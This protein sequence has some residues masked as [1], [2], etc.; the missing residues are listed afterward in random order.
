MFDGPNAVYALFSTLS[1]MLE[2][3][4]GAVLLIDALDECESGPE[5]DQLLQL[6]TKH[7]KSPTKAKWLLASRNYSSIKQLLEE[8]SETLSLE[9]NEQHISRAVH[10]FI[11][12]KTNELVMK[13]KYDPD[14]AEKVKKGLT[15]KANSTF[16]WVSLACKSLAKASRWKTLSTLENLPSG[17]G[18][19]YARMMD[20]VLQ[21]EDEED[22]AFCM[23]ILRSVSLSFRPLLM[24][25]LIIA[26]ELPKEFLDD[27]SISNSISDLIELCGSFIIVR[28]RVPYFVHQSAKDYLV[29]DGSQRLF[30]PG[31]RL[32]HGLIVGRSLIAMSNK[33]KRNMGNLRYSGSTPDDAKINA[34]L[35]AISYVCSFW[36]EHLASF[37]S[38]IFIN[39]LSYKEYLSDQGHIHQ[40][41]LKHLLHWFEAL[42]L[43]GHVNSGIMGLHIFGANVWTAD[44][45]AG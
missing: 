21:G 31:L 38:D 4:P 30:P 15:A 9:L 18:D 36:V 43:F 20:L 34:H 3:R 6:I 14:L 17:L 33:L 32:E 16:I 27:D 29:G 42:S 2:A 39:D 40:F 24:E 19:L 26:A 23:Q 22:T 8:E 44:K 35:K 7:A 1:A 11:A 25:E 45:I 13:K 37:L 5:R 10:A 41:L 12:K 28:E